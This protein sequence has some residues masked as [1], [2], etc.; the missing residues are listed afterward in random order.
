[1]RSS[2]QLL[3]TLFAS[4]YLQR[5]RFSKKDF[6]EKTGFERVHASGVTNKLRLGVDR[7]DPNSWG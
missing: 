6:A 2:I 1:M 3:N 7:G 5:K 4:P